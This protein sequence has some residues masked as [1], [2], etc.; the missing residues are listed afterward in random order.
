MKTLSP[1]AAFSV[2]VNRQAAPL[3]A[4]PGI[5]D[6]ENVEF[7]PLRGCS[8]RAPTRH[9]AKL[10]VA[11]VDRTKDIAEHIWEHR[12]GTRY[13]VLLQGGSTPVVYDA[14]TGAA[15]TV[16][17][18][19]GTPNYNYLGGVSDAA[20]LRC[21]DAGDYLIVLHTGTLPALASTTA[22]SKASTAESFVFVKRANYERTYTVAVTVGGATYSV[23]STTYTQ[24][25]SPPVVPPVGKVAPDSSTIATNLAALLT[26]ALA[27]P[28]GGA[29]TAT[30]T[31]SVVRIT[32]N[33]VVLGV[34]QPVTAVRVSD[35]DGNNS[36]V[37]M[38]DAVEDISDLPTVCKDGFKI[39]VSASG[40]TD[41]DDYFVKF[42]ANDPTNASFGEGHWEETVDYGTYTSWDLS[43]MPHAL[44]R[45][46][47]GG[48]YQFRWT[49]LPWADRLVGADRT[50]PWPSFVQG[51]NGAYPTY[52]AQ[53]SVPI[54]DV[55]YWQN[56]L[57]LV[58][59][60]SV[61]LSE[62]DQPFNLFRTSVRSV[63]PSDPI[64]VQG[65]G[66][67][68]VR[69]LGGTPNDE[70]L[71]LH[72]KR[73]Q[74]ALY[75]DG[76][77]TPA[78]VQMA[79]V[80]AAETDS[81][82]RCRA[83]A[84][85]RS[86]FLPQVRGIYGAVKELV[87]TGATGIQF[88]SADITAALPDWIGH[89]RRIIADPGTDAVFAQDT[90]M[91]KLFVHRFMWNGGQ[92]DHASWTRYKFSTNLT[93]YRVLGTKLYM[94]FNHTDG[95]YLEHFDTTLDESD[96]GFDYRISLDRRVKTGAGLTA[97]YDSAL[98]E[99]VF[100]FP[101]QIETG[102]VLQLVSDDGALYNVLT[103]SAGPGF[104]AYA[105]V[106]GDKTAAT[107]YGGVQYR[108]YLKIDR[109][110]LKDQRGYA[111]YDPEATVLYGVIQ[112]D[113]SGPFV[114]KIN[115]AD[116]RTFESQAASGIGTVGSLVGEVTPVSGGHR[117]SVLGKETQVSIEI[118]CDGPIPF[119]LQGVTWTHRVSA[120]G[121]ARN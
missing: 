1:P 35:G 24:A 21:L 42:V 77:L 61:T 6:A 4:P 104:A 25:Q 69:F 67:N 47:S 92:K 26:A 28:T 15:A 29:I 101:Y 43:T 2:G 85:G 99:T 84:N 8:K 113:R 109:P 31:G 13:G 80:Q 65:S 51:L 48:V 81:T 83:V 57:G 32:G 117:F 39:K 64:D 106:T 5:T 105:A 100:T 36:L 108:A 107:V 89:L 78:T 54:E 63:V 90:N 16:S 56:R 71:L 72:S 20:Y 114:V 19:A 58:A 17:L 118:D 37:A 14:D 27:G 87:R 74:H 86:V 46:F 93:S 52:S 18:K 44:E 49:R 11:G 102:D 59:G 33:W 103:Q 22:A 94:V 75:Y 34:P 30:A 110:L 91:N 55:I 40:E 50:N 111:S 97:S 41:A 70:L 7:S 68:L 3:R 10:T 60:S 115:F 9:I 88:A 82:Y 112:H 73:G 95:F 119:S 116:G 45:F 121:R 53:T 12:D 120:R 62:V 98:N 96:T 79:F 76:T 66:P 23:T 38:L